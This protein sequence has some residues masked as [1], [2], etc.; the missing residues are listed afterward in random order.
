MKSLYYLLLFFILS[1][2]IQSCSAPY[3]GY[4][5]E[6]WDSF[7]EQEKVTIKKEYQV[8]TSI[9]NAQNHTDKINERTQSVI[10]YGVSMEQ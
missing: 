6:K 4:T 5:K 1:T 7:T 10:D 9:R 3:Y 2:L 8:I